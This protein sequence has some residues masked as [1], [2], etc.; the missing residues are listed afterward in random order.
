MSAGEAEA[1]ADV[2]V[3]AQ[4]LTI[5]L[6]V[7]QVS[8]LEREAKEL[9]NRSL[10][11]GEIPF[12]TVDA[13]FQLVRPFVGFGIMLDRGGNFYDLGSGCGKVVRLRPHLYS[14]Q[15]KPGNLLRQIR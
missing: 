14:L 8:R 13:V 2:S 4:S 10:V 9:A 3:S 12:E 11:Y 5:E 7:K 1:E 6:A 15:P